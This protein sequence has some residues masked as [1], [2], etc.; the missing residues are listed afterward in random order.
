MCFQI[1]FTWSDLSWINWLVEE[2]MGLTPTHPVSLGIL[3]KPN[4]SMWS[5]YTV[6]CPKALALFIGIPIHVWIHSRVKPPQSSFNPDPYQD[7][8]KAFWTQD[9]DFLP[10]QLTQMPAGRPRVTCP[11]WC[12]RQ[13]LSLHSVA[14][15]SVAG[16]DEDHLPPLCSLWDQSALSA[17]LHLAAMSP[18]CALL[19]GAWRSAA[20]QTA[21]SKRGTGGEGRDGIERE[22]GG[23]DKANGWRMLSGSGCALCS[24]GLREGRTAT[25]GGNQDEKWIRDEKESNRASC[26]E[27]EI[28]V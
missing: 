26:K 1:T 20:I 7:L 13:S 19:F 15:P 22:G 25:R 28:E 27:K 16:V 24:S 12:S 17:A 5:R 11:I 2:V 9:S 18:L 6:L 8:T 23:R 21:A 4:M 3:E 14:F 10:V